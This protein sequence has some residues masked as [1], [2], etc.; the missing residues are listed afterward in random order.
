MG[1]AGFSGNDSFTHEARDNNGG[2]SAAA[3]L[4]IPATCTIVCGDY[5]G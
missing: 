3:T 5:T 1:N 2:A 4:N